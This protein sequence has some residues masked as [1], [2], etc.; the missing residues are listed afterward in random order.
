MFISWC[1]IVKDDSEVE[2][3]KRCVGSVL[4]YVEE[5]VITAN[6]EVVTEIEK[7]CATEPKI[8]FF[9][10]KWT[11]NFAEQRNICASKVSSNADYY[12]WSDSDDVL[13]GGEYLRQTAEKARKSNLD[14]VF[15]TYWYSCLFDGEPSEATMKSIE[16]TQMRERLLKPGVTVWKKRL[17]ETPVPVDNI[18]FQHGVF[19]YSEDAPI[20]WLHLGVHRE[21]VKGVV[22]DP[23]KNARN[24]ELLELQLEDERATSGAD[25]RTLIYLMKIYGEADDEETLLKTIEMGNEYLTKSGWNAERGMCCCI[26]GKCLGKLGRDRE[27]KQLLF[28]AIGEYPFDPML[29]LYLSKSCGNLKQYGEMR[30]WL[31]V[32]L[33][34]DPN[35]SISNVSNLL[36]LKLMAAEQT[37]YYNFNGARDIRKAYKA[38][39]ILAKEMP[40]PENMET[41]NYLKGVNDLEEASRVAHELMIFY[42]EQ[43]NHD[44]VVKIVESMPDTMR[45]LP[46]AWAMYNKHKEPKVWGE[47]EICYYAN[48]AKPHLEHW[49]GNSLTQGLGGSETAV[50]K[51]AE[52]WTKKGWV[53]TVYGDPLVRTQINGV[54]YLPYFEFNSRDFFNIFIQWRSSFLAHRIKAKKFLVDLHDLWSPQQF[55]GNVNQIDKF[56][57]KS[58]FQKDMG[59]G[60][61]LEKFTVIS[62]GI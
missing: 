15:F 53:V 57:V 56:M 18:D 22:D 27:A 9:Y 21:I 20:A 2:S 35:Q 41:L 3:L 47:K 60:I 36:E 11:K 29:Y 43:G 19:K 26:M 5:M 30:H 31:E 13:V 50:I 62:N 52:E 7:F 44:G 6:G 51:L 32:A 12:G 16:L 48:F 39:Q 17:H 59:E 24:R 34:M 28:D 10:H 33:A 23:S 61:E 14:V 49:D 25:P 46:F 54:W 42:Q 8:K 45:N 37:M 4:P 55:K 58:N 38:M 1:I 40:T